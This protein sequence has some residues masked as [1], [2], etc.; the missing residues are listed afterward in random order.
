MIKN[1]KKLFYMTALLFG[2]AGTQRECSAMSAEEFG[3][4][5]VV[6]QMD[7]GGRPFRCW[8]LTD[9]SIAN[10][11]HSDGVWWRSR[12]GHLVHISGNYNRVQVNGNN[13]RTAFSEVG[14]TEQT[15]REIQGI[16]YNPNETSQ[17]TENLSRE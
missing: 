17:T 2:C 16:M 4:N 1:L 12:E 11:P 7:M 14:L 3:A 15:C 10:E 13:W 5:W 6:V 8:K 9:V